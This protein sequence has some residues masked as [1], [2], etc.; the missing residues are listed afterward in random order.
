[1][2]L[3]KIFGAFVASVVAFA[4]LPSQAAFKVEI[5]VNGGPSLLIVDDGANDAVSGV[6]GL[7]NYTG[8][9]G[10]LANVTVDTATSNRTDGVGNLASLSNSIAVTN[11][12]NSVL[13]FVVKVTDTGY[14]FPV[15]PTFG[16]VS[17]ATGGASAGFLGG[18]LRSYFNPNDTEFAQQV[19]VT[20]ADQ[21][22]GLG[23][24]TGSI[25]TG[26]V[27]P[28]GLTQIITFSL[29]AGVGKSTPNLVSTTQVLAPEPTSLALIVM[30]GVGLVGG[31]VRRRRASQ[32]T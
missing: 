25:M 21:N 11:L 3:R 17:E 6:A 8:S 26:G 22:F 13:N 31:A 18:T 14:L 9:V 5:T 23:T 20:P 24:T 10:A 32:S 4:A 15:G 28:Y 29:D 16:I 27:T 30:G 1:M 7:I 12:T 2:S 19:A